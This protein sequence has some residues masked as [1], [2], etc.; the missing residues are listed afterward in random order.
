LPSETEAKAKE[1]ASDSKRE[2]QPKNSL[3]QKFEKGKS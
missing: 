3:K 2:G 1:D